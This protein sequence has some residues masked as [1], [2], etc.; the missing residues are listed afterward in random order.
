MTLRDTAQ[1]ADL[2]PASTQITL[3]F[4]LVELETF[5]VVVELGSFSLAARRLHISQPSV[6]S[7]VQRLE[8]M[9]KTK[10]LTRTTRHVAPTPAGKR[11]QERAVHALRDLRALLQEFQEEAEEARF[12]VVIASTPMISA[13]MLP[14]LIHQFGLR[15]PDV[16]IQLRD[17]QYEEVV[18]KIEA[19]EVDFAVVAFDGDSDKFEFEPLSEENFLL[20][21]PSSHALTN[22]DQITLTQLADVPLMMLGRYASLQHLLVHELKN[23]NITLKPPQE[24]VNLSTLLGMVD[25]GLGATLLPRSMAQLYAKVNRSTLHLADFKLV[26]TFGILRARNASLSPASLSFLAFLKENFHTLLAEQA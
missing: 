6:T 15:Y 7:R 19:N 20:V 25:A 17:V 22:A 18:A 16:N 2:A 11:L 9:L 23:R 5:L 26:R 1:Q 14:T 12:R 13:V 24:V 8:S 4:D 21:A 3:R 10:L